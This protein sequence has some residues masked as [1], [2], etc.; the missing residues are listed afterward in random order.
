MNVVNMLLG[1]SLALHL[2]KRTRHLAVFVGCFIIQSLC[3]ASPG[4]KIALIGADPSGSA[5][6]SVPAW[7]GGL[8]RRAKNAQKHH[9]N[10][11][12]S[13]K[14][15]LTI[16]A[17]NY[18]KHQDRLTPGLIALLH[19]YPE[20]FKI[21]VYPSHRSASYPDWFYQN[22]ENID[23]PPSLAANG[24]GI[25]NAIA[26][27]NFP[28]P[29]NGL[30][31]IWNHL[32]RWRGRYMVRNLSEAIVYANGDKKLS[33]LRQEVAYELFREGA[34]TNNDRQVLLH[35]A[36]FITAPANLAGG[37]LLAI[38]YLNQH[39]NP[40]QTWSYDAGQRRIKRLPYVTYDGPAVMAESL[41]TA[42]DTDMY[43]GSP[44]HYDW[45]LR[46]KRIIYI[47]YNSY[48]SSSPDI[49]YDTLLSPHHINPEVMRFEA[50]RVWVL[51]ANLKPEMHHIYP[52]RVFYLD[53]DSWSIAIADQYDRQ[54]KI[55]RV[56]MALLKNYYEI[57]MT[58]S[59]ADVFH[60][61][62][63]KNYH[64][65]GMT[66]EER[67]SGE[68]LDTLPPPNHFTPGALRARVRR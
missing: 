24:N 32:T 60:D 20:S 25:D 28:H 37:A 39:Q 14:P 15:L 19:T 10:P 40:R 23:T 50:H 54:G 7:S 34:E 58:F 44:D 26:G 17:N 29:E 41:R 38:D 18:R 67:S 42:D 33:K 36:S 11:Y 53:E 47:P 31:A 16:D 6:G 3:A 2:R 63:S 65:G 62:K 5:D 56:S 46:G 52:K 55:W 57:P 27:F 22:I 48:R 21:P 59:S 51:E 8:E 9:D 61:L 4:A 49:S 43:N 35:Y 13:E 66:N 1:A 68:F 45:Q 64:V 12:A 30:E